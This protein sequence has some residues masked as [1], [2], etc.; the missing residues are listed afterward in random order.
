MISNVPTDLK[1]LPE[2]A[3]KMWF[4]GEEHILPEEDL[5]RLRD[6]LVREIIS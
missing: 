2:L 4:E 6:Y 1:Y 3:L 5:K